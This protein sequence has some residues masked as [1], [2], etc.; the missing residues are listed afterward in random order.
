MSEQAIFIAALDILDPLERA[1]YVER[2][3]GS[4]SALRYQ[5]EAL[6]A[7]HEFSGDF[8]DIPALKQMAGDAPENSPSLN[9]TSAEYPDAEGDVD[10][11]FLQPSTKHGSL[12]RLTHYEIQEVIGRGGCGI[13]LKATD[14]VLQRTVAIKVMVPEVAA[15][16]PARKRF[17]REARAAAA[18]RHENVVSIHAV[19]EQPIPF[20]VMEYIGGQT[21]QQK[22][23]QNGPL[24]LQ[25][26][27]RIGTQVARGL[28]AAHKMGLIHR[29]IKPSNILIERDCD[30]IKITDFGLARAADDA[31]ITQ[32]GAI[33]GTP[34]YMSPEQA[35]GATLDHRSD[36]FSLGSVL[37][38]M[39]SGRPPF[40]AASALAVL[41]RVATD[42]PRP[43][44]DIIPEVPEWLIA[45][46]GRLHAKN[47]AGRFVHAKEV[48]DLLARCLSEL[49]QLGHVDSFR[50]V[51]PAI[52]KKADAA[53]GSSPSVISKAEQ[54]QV[55]MHSRLAPARS[56]RWI[57]AVLA[58]TILIGGF[59]TTE[60]TG[61]TDVRGTVIRLFSPDGVL[62]VEVD[63][64]S[65]SVSIDGEDMVITGSGTKEIRLKPGQYK[66]LARKDGKLLSDELV[67][68]TRNGR[69][70]VRVSKEF[71][72]LPDQRNHAEAPLSATGSDRAA[73]EYVLSIGGEAEIEMHGQ[74]RRIAAGS[75]LPSEDFQI[76]AVRLN[77]MSKV[78]DAGLTVFSDCTH[79]KELMLAA[80]P[81][82]D[83]GLSHFK[84][85]RDL[86]YLNVAQSQVTDAGLAIFRGCAHLTHLI[87][88]GQK[89][90]TDVGLANF[91]DCK[92]L[93]HLNVGHTSV[94]DDGLVHFHSCNLEN[95]YLGPS[96]T[97]TDKSL[98]LFGKCKNLSSLWLT[99]AQFTDR[100]LAHFDGCK[101]LTFL[102]L[103]GSSL[104]DVAMAN[105]R[106]SKDLVELELTGVQVT[107]AGLANF[108]HCRSLSALGL[109]RTRATDAGLACFKDCK[110][111]TRLR[112]GDT[113][114]S[115][116]GLANFMNCKNLQYLSLFDTQ[117]SDTALL[118]LA[119][120]SGL[121]ELNI[122]NTRI[123]HSGYEQ[124]K[125][126]LPKCTIAWSEPNRSVATDVLALGGTIEI[127]P[128]GN[129]ESHPIPAAIALPAGYFQVRRVSL[130]GVTKPLETLPSL[131]AKLKHSRFDRLQSLDLSGISGMGDYNWLAAIHG[132]EDLTL[133][134]A[135]VHAGTLT[136]LP[137][138]L[139][140]L[141]LDGNPA[142]GSGLAT[143]EKQTVLTELSLANASLTDQ[144]L[145]HLPRLPAL[146]R[147][148]LDGNAINGAGIDVLGLQP[149][150]TDL[151][152]NSAKLTDLT[153]KKLLKL[154]NLQRLSL[155]GNAL[156]D[157]GIMQLANL[158]GL[159]LL[160]L[161]GTTAT[162]AG[163]NK[164]AAAIP[165]C[166]VESDYATKASEERR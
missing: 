139:K 57:A 140:R 77:Y 18:I 114:L 19:E 148:V 109:E 13:V 108:Q 38:V 4:D 95:L 155:A 113:E 120:L 165:H 55:A 14:E 27:L 70:V 134:N 3:C 42:Q 144:S 94:S 159:E 102:Y 36:L 110:D 152:L 80:Y 33:A 30:R 47:P 131:I 29:D 32:S 123:S 104:S 60:A 85:C 2:A 156:T 50:E 106:D 157:A 10:L 25:E 162:E 69:Q 71:Q 20:L 67:T 138:T 39:C 63:D 149:E 161:R 1:A 116:E 75:I 17:L 82:S 111:L 15:T 100:G 46:I 61:V 98:A 21:L 99:S 5:V 121:F 142:V 132:L 125:A 154:K 141:V 101:N 146:A 9:T 53:V 23:D 86:T 96:D 88:E 81:V 92:N 115:D 90:V 28:E 73:A 56:H 164:L 62:V 64:P 93:T 87:L 112:L 130:A 153:C 37:Y 66:L 11:S 127:G 65:V 44:R 89:G 40:R 158:T 145:L 7:A 49:E 137:P 24:D 51:V 151:S 105:F 79:V 129:R 143:L 136:I 119:G 76:T 78:S 83:V 135:G 118:D 166:K 45:I 8:L 35:Q 43:I 103:T 122:T 147:L 16:S 26:V 160:D 124:L 163:L 68:V 133:A 91:E 150:L 126:V 54:G 12:A 74:A 22:L 34:L 6:L 41:K 128:V 97:V 59:T 48:A 117:V 72:T 58:S 107:D 52:P 31:S 84:N